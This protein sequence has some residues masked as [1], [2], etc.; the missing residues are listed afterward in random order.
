MNDNDIKVAGEIVAHDAQQCAA[1]NEE[2]K[3]FYATPVAKLIEVILSITKHLYSQPDLVRGTV[4]HELKHSLSDRFPKPLI[5]NHARYILLMQG[6][7]ILRRTSRSVST[8]WHVVDDMMLGEFTRHDFVT[9]QIKILARR[10]CEQEKSHYRK[11]KV[12]SLEQRVT[13]L[14][15][16]LTTLQA[17]TPPVAESQ[18]SPNSTALED[19]AVDLV[20]RFEV[21]QEENTKLLEQV[22]SLTKLELS[23][24]ARTAELSQEI[25]A[26]KAGRGDILAEAIAK[27][28]A[29]H[30]KQ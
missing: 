10:S 23:S 22:D 9:S 21:L 28:M 8:A 17:S 13:E 15:T 19:Q 3:N 12:S 20:I 4:Y 5:L 1:A 16:E 25:V 7:G 30:N 2:A 18:A 6:L 27:R 24:S 14:H 26:M 29:A 11:L